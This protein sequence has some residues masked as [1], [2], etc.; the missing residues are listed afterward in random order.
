MRQKLPILTQNECF[1]TVTQYSLGWYKMVLID[2]D[3]Q[4]ELVHFECKYLTFSAWQLKH[5]G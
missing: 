1:R 2:I 5:S 4:G 3:F